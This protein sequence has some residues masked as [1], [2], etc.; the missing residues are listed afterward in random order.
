MKSDSPW[1]NL[2]SKKKIRLGCKF[3]KEK[4]SS[5]SAQSV[6]DKERVFIVFIQGNYNICVKQKILVLNETK[7][8]E[9]LF[10]PKV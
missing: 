2:A 9:I 8:D 6:S 7:Q 1:Y 3:G 4:H 10:K 5:L